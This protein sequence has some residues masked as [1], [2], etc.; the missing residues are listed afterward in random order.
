MTFLNRAQ[1]ISLHSVIVFVAV[2]LAAG[3]LVWL[4]APVNAG[5]S[6]LRMQVYETPL[7]VLVVLAILLGTG[8][9]LSFKSLKILPMVLSGFVIFCVVFNAFASYQEILKFG[10]NQDVFTGLINILV[11]SA[12]FPLLI[13]Q[14][15]ITL[16]A[17]LGLG[18]IGIMVIKGFIITR[19]W[20]ETSPVQQAILSFAFG[21]GVTAFLTF[22]LA[23]LQLLTLRN[24]LLTDAAFFCAVVLIPPHKFRVPDIDISLSTR[25][26]KWWR[27]IGII[28]VVG[29]VYA[30]LF[31]PLEWDSLAYQA[32][33]SKLVYEEK[34]LPVIFGPSIG[35]EMSAA[36]PPAYQMLGC[37]T[38]VLS[39]DSNAQLMSVLSYMAGVLS[40]VVTFLFA[41]LVLPSHRMYAVIVAVAVPFFLGFSASPHYM[42]LLIFF[43]GLFL[44]HI[45]SYILTGNTTSLYISVICLGVACLTSYLALASFLFLVITYARQKFPLRT[46]LLPAVISSPPLL[47]NLF[48]TGNPLFPL[49]GLGYQLQNPLWDSN[50]THFQTQTLYAGLNVLSPFS[51]L[52]FLFNRI[53]SVRPLLPLTMV[54]GLL[55]LVVFRPRARE[56][57]WLAVW[58]L[59]CIV[60][61]LVRPTFDRYL[62]VYIPVY[63]TFFAWLIYKCEI[64]SFKTLKHSLQAGLAVSLSIVILGIVITGPLMVASHMKQFP[65][66]PL[67]DWAYVRQFYP[68]DTPCW[69]FLNENTPPGTYVATYDIRYYYIDQKIFSLDGLESLPLYEMDY[70]E[71]LTFLREHE[72]AYWFSSRWTSPADE[73]CPP[74]YYDN[75]LTPYLGSDILPLVF[76]SGQS[77][78]Y[79][80]G[81]KPIDYQELLSTEHVLYP[82]SGYEFKFSQGGMVYFDIPGDYQGK[83]IVLSFSENVKASLHGGHAASPVLLG[84][85]LYWAEGEPM[86]F[87]AYS[88][89]YTLYLESE[90][91]FTVVVSIK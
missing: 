29:M 51:I 4:N 57:K 6:W 22:L 66:Q 12:A 7:E 65:D 64:L 48:Y 24:V 46:F 59:T 54:V 50:T 69:R 67:D 31:P 27:L 2:A 91:P 41:G 15:D 68:H 84:E 1:P 14:V 13:L 11:H 74:A 5:L 71:A 34:G 9:A 89:K 36:Y 75:P 82:V 61:F 45:T 20:I 42:T 18:A 56:R 37:Y 87:T 23:A 88:G 44:L 30:V 21:F 80:I 76:I 58:F 35:I 3:I 25:E 62:L 85:T 19:K 38:Y 26:K 39:G 47:R 73:T 8:T 53:S 10:I 40:L 52:D 70:Q 33:Y 32:Y 55:F 16:S 86:R 78:V 60:I 79:N 83:T 43:N 17:L 49:F 72:V 81:S 90:G 63:S 77:A 28:L